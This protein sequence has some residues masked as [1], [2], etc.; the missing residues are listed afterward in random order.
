MR[1]LWGNIAHTSGAKI[2]SLLIGVLILSLTARLLG[3]EGRGQFA[4][5]STWVGMFSSFA[6]LSLGQVALHRMASDQMKN[7][8]GHLLGSLLLVT[9]I[10][11]LVGWLH[12]LC[13]GITQKGHSKGCRCTL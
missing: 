4:T 7:R 6:Y 13:I 10:V 11:T 5:I 2:Y 1:E 12:W 3:P 9:I 8:F